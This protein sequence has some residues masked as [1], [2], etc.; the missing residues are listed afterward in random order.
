MIWRI[1]N[2]AFGPKLVLTMADEA[3]QRVTTVRVAPP[4]KLWVEAPF[5]SPF[6][7]ALV[8]W[9]ISSLGA[10]QNGCGLLLQDLQD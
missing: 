1:W 4:A 6:Q 9:R 8:F 5:Q 7:V 10:D 3:Q 2:V